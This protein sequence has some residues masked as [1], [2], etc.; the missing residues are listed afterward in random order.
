MFLSLLRT[1]CTK[2][3]RTTVTWV[4]FAVY[5]GMVVVAGFFM[6]MM[7]NPGIAERL[8]LMGQK[9]KFAFGGEAL[10][11]PTFLTFVQEMGGLGSLIMS[12][13]I[14]T[15]VF[16]REYAEGTAKNLLAL[17]IPRGHFVLAKIGVSAAWLA[18]LT[19]WLLPVT[20]LAGS[21][22]GLPGF[23][24][25]AVS[26]MMVRLA[27][28]AGMSLCCSTLVAWIGVETRGYFAPLGFAVG[29]LVLASV[30]GHTGWAPWVPWSIV[31]IYS[32]AAGPAVRI[33][34]GSVVVLVATFAAGLSLTIRHEVH[35]D[36]VQ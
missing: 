24:P 15:F 2:L 22:V 23:A 13:V 11:W 3:R 19:L 29:T 8:G 4:T 5:A 34:W 27:A 17:S 6:W 20:L 14:V 31:G 10:D 36:N 33:G 26:A 18:A 16:G 9:A 32:G 28:L 21:M 30:F 35:A 1:E 25:A 7:K 12:S